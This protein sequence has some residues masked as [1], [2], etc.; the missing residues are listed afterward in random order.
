MI[1]M[2]RRSAAEATVRGGGSVEPGTTT[3][4]CTP[5]MLTLDELLAELL[6]QLLICRDRTD[7]LAVRRLAASRRRGHA[8][9][10]A[11]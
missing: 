6:V 9:A 2:S 5:G 8:D 7:G 10:A 3:I 1:R 11:A 4:G